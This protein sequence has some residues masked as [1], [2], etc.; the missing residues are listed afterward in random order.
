M[1]LINKPLQLFFLLFTLILLSCAEN[2]NHK[3]EI[4]GEWTL[5]FIVTT[6]D[7]ENADSEIVRAEADEFGCA[8]VILVDTTETVIITSEQRHCSTLIFNE[9]NTVTMAS[10]NVSDLGTFNLDFLIDREINSVE[11]CNSVKVC[12]E[13]LLENGELSTEFPLATMSPKDCMR[14]FV[15][16]K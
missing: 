14:T 9:D 1:E 8:T 13:Y 3:E 15:Y 4:L 16:R 10:G 5:K 11:L 12:K 2:E 7:F 6:C